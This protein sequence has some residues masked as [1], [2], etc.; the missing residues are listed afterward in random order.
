MR[1]KIR[2]LELMDS[3]QDD[4][5]SKR[6][7]VIHHP[8]HSTAFSDFSSII[9][10][11]RNST[12][13]NLFMVNILDSYHVFSDYNEFYRY[14]RFILLSNLYSPRNLE[15]SKKFKGKRSLDVK[16]S[17]KKHWKSLVHLLKG[18]F[19]FFHSISHVP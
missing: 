5:H 11:M 10:N 14:P 17:N 1:S 18:V 6:M 3:T 7:M 4:L 9:G 16:D 8:S 12:S 13:G 2:T 19:T 15:Y